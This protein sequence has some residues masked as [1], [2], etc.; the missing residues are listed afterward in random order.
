[1]HDQI[2]T[3]EVKQSTHKGHSPPL[4]ALSN[5]SVEE[6]D[7][8]L[9]K[10]HFVGGLDCPDWILAEVASLSKLPVLKFK[11]W[12]LSCVECLIEG[13]TEWNDVHLSVLNVDQNLDDESVK[14][15]LAALVFILEKSTKNL[16]SAQDLEL[17]MQQLEH[18]KQLTKIY[19]LNLE[20]LKNVLLSSFRRMPSLTVTSLDSTEKGIK[21]VTGDI[22]GLVSELS[23]A[24]DV[25]RP[26]VRNVVGN[27]H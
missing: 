4:R 21:K 5:V 3:T 27:T 14:R 24:M 1:M 26:F 25:M 12:C 22:F 11:H 17:E 6:N 20:K 18:C 16:C 9:Q 2:N 13:R 10:F 23:Q 8:Y 15:M 19:A 7:S